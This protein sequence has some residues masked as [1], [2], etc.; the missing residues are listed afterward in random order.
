MRN[1]LALMIAAGLLAS[2]APAQDI[3]TLDRRLRDQEAKT[4]GLEQ[5][6]QM[7][8]DKASVREKQAELWSQMQTTQSELADMKGQLAEL[9][10]RMDA[11]K[12]NVTQNAATMD[13]LTGDIRDTNSLLKQ[14]AGQLGVELV[15]ETAET[16]PAEAAA[17]NATAAGDAEEE[18]AQAEA[19]EKDEAKELYDKALAAFKDNRYGDAQILWDEFANTYKDNALVP[20]A[21]FWQGESYYQ[22]KDYARAVLK[23]QDVIDKHA[24]SNKYRAALLKQGLSFMKLGRVN[25]GRLLLRDV[26]EKFPDSAEAKRAKSILAGS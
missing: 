6:L 11:L 22:M 4:A 9:D 7:E 26:V 12:G 19:P 25:A 17:G 20:N 10:R 24:K 1:V 18:P 21:L 2:C 3:K 23:Y 8:S 14:M 5:Q 15:E 13:K 16:A